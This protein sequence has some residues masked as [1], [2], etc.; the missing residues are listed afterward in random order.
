MGVLVGTSS[1]G[2]VL[3]PGSRTPTEWQAGEGS[4]FPGAAGVL[5]SFGHLGRR[6]VRVSQRVLFG[7]DYETRQ[8]V[9]YQGCSLPPR[10]LRRGLGGAFHSDEFYLQ[11]GVV[12]A[13]RLATRLG[14]TRAS[15]LVDIGCGLG[16][17]AT[18]MLWE[19]GEVH[20]MGLDAN[21]QYIEWCQNHIE[22]VHPSFRFVH[23]D[24]V[25]ELY[26][27][28]GSID[29]RNIRLPL[30]DGE[31]DIVYLWGVF[32]NMGPEHVSTYVSEISR[33]ATEG[34]QIFLTAYVEADVSEV[35][36]NPEGYGPFLYSVPQ[37]VVRYSKKHLF[38][39]FERDGLAV[40]EFRHHGGAFPCQSEIYLTKRKAPAL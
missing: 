35:S 38:S 8:R 39:L 7:R 2:R 33:V 32:T 11:S 22:R 26:N 27:P 3:A 16:R 17:L 13:R 37:H 10:H 1:P 4:G 20:Y 6:A 34:A 40:E 23:L 30:P 31:A 15:R 14:Y 28:L 9:L 36:F 21:Q 25:N 19:Y 29:G 12:E 24:V 5:G 18:G